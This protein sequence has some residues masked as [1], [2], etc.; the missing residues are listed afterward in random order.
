M[1]DFATSE[2]NLTVIQNRVAKVR[3]SLYDDDVAFFVNPDK[4][5]VAVTNEILNMFGLG[6]GAGYQQ[7]QECSLSNPMLRN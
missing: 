4:E 2:G 1:F 3:M 7:R 5:E 6:V